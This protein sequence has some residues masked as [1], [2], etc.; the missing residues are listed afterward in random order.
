VEQVT[1]PLWAYDLCLLHEGS[2]VTCQLGPPAPWLR[3]WTLVSCSFQDNQLKDWAVLNIV[4]VLPCLPRL[5]KL[6]LSRNNVSVSTL[7]CLTKV[8]VA[9]PTVRT[10]QVR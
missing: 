5:Q 4:E 3:D 2:H 1:N 10:L 8:A 9:C 7:L 6:D